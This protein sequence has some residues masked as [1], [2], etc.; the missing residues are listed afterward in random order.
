MTTESTAPLDL[1]TEIAWNEQNLREE[2]SR[3]P[4]GEVL[5]VELVAL[6]CA[7]LG[8]VASIAGH[9]DTAVGLIEHALPKL[10]ALEDPQFAVG[11]RAR[12]VA[13]LA[14]RGN[15]DEAVALRERVMAEFARLPS[16]AAEEQAR[17]MCEMIG[18]SVVYMRLRT[19]TT[20]VQSCLEMFPFREKLTADWMRWVLEAAE[21]AGAEEIAE[22][23]RQRMVK[24][25]QE[26]NQP[27][28]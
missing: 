22:V 11:A 13:V 17:P 3:L 20:L 2:S 10:D 26:D 16:D 28:G 6:S 7:N 25:G 5:P 24:L 15:I 14:R 21:T 1:A 9:Y 19:S 27:G 8:W 4:P 23:V 18:Y 12:Q